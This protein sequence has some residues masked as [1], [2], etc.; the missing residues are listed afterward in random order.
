MSTQ[1]RE[2]GV[3]IS[4]L[5]E[6][7][8]QHVRLLEL[9]PELLALLTGECPPRLQLKSKEDLAGNAKDANVVL[10]TPDRTYN[11]RQV[12]TS[13]SVYLTQTTEKQDPGGGP[14]TIG[15]EA[16]AK[17]DTT[18]E[19]LSTTKQS[20]VP[21]IKTALPVFSSNGNYASA[22]PVT[23][24]ELFAHIPL[25]QA[26]CE[27]GWSELACFESPHPRGCYVPSAKVKSEIWQLALTAAT[28]DGISLTDPFPDDDIPAF[29][30]DI[31]QDWPSE[32][33]SSVLK[34][35]SSLTPGG[36][37]A[38]DE[39]KAVRF[40]GINL[41]QAKSEGRAIEATGFLRAWRDVLP[42][43]WRDKCEFTALQGS[44]ALQDGGSMI[45]YI[46]TA[47]AT[48]ATTDSKSL[49]AKRKWHEKFAASR[50][51]A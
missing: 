17:C 31:C 3:P 37:F 8:L 32:L 27:E 41:L 38:L 43:A 34:G 11:V 40:A 20:A 13:N 48:I 26:E 12:S 5:P 22:V 14:P 35:G 6:S 7:D 45:K 19:L 15:V 9:P 30:M 4:V 46:D 42:E 2:A 44:Y 18:I 28:A 1:D 51:K 47:P 29:A 49:G 23:K 39:S 25:S 33:V 10:C 16:V 21:F 50:K 36:H 24:A